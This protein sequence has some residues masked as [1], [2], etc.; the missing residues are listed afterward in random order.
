MDFDKAIDLDRV[1]N[2]LKANNHW[3]YVYTQQ[4]NSLRH[5]F[6]HGYII[7]RFPEN[8]DWWE[9]SL[10]DIGNVDDIKMADETPNSFRDRYMSYFS[11]KS[12]E[13]SLLVKID[14]GRYFDHRQRF[15]PRVGGEYIPNTRGKM[16]NY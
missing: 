10:G 12:R 7:L 13:Y 2:F 9:R 14:K 8:H 16:Y 1:V 15:I 5:Y 6:L 4:H 11:D 3:A